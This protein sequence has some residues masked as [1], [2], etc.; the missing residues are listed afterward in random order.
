MKKLIV[1]LLLIFGVF[2][3]YFLT[4]SP[5]VYFG[6]SGEYITT[7]YVLGVPHPPGFP[8]YVALAHIFTKIPFGTIAWRVNLFSAILGAI[9]VFLVYLTCL[10]L[11]KRAVPSAVAA[12]VLAFSPIFWLYS[13]VAESFMINNLFF[14]L[15]IYLSLVFKDN[16]ANKKVF[17]LLSFVFGLALTPHQLNFFMLP[18][19]LV[20]LWFYRR[21][22]LNLKDILLGIVFFV[23]G[24]TPYLYFPLAAL[25]QPPYNWGDPTTPY[26]IFR[27]IM[28]L[29]YGLFALGASFSK[30]SEFT[31]V[32]LGFYFLS[33]IRQFSIFGVVLGILGLFFQKRSIRILKFFVLLFLFTGPIFL[34]YSRLQFVSIFQKGVGE[35]FFMQSS[36]I[37]VLWIGYGVY[38][39]IKFIE[40]RVPRKRKIFFTGFEVLLILL[41]LLLIPLNNS[42][43]NQSKNFLY[44][45]YGINTLETLP[46]NSL[47]LVSNDSGFMITAYLSMV[48]QKRPDVKIVNFSLLP[49]DWY[50][51]QI[52][53]R[54]PDLKLPNAT[55]DDS[56]Q[57]IARTFCKDYLSNQPTFIDA[58]SPGLNPED[59]K[60]CKFI[61]KGVVIE[62]LSNNA[63]FDINKYKEENDKLWN[64]Y[65]DFDKLTK[66]NPADFRTREMLYHYSDAINYVGMTYQ[67][68]GKKDWAKE[69]YQLSDRVSKDNGLSRSNLAS[70]LASEGKYDEAIKLE[71]EAIGVE[72][73]SIGSY[74]NL[75]IWYGKMKNDKVKGAYYLR[76]YLDIVP[77]DKHKEDTDNMEKLLKEFEGK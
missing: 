22:I 32:P 74:R 6:D 51:K 12:L 49:A 42:Y 73:R 59:N 52:A 5:S 55:L 44:Y 13:E 53:K 63:A 26:R 4:L 57:K 24:L 60:E 17:Y 34:F 10:R 61:R 62:L 69:M 33:F 23:L 65:L 58:W 75:G 3:V 54:Y 36:I 8:L 16:L 56:V 19:L 25:R 7:A 28:R 21:H 41:P 39:I 47:F 11:T 1:P 37:F 46:K 68:S 48:E 27:Q 31:L 29:D 43:A 38:E 64:S 40:K 30:N 77:R 45:N 72:A 70:I 2:V 20:F 18:A 14:I 15:V 35:R 9:T 71:E 67:E 66:I 76:K 50:K